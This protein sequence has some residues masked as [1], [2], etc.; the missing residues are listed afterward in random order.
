MR[1]QTAAFAFLVPLA[2]HFVASQGPA[3]AAMRSCLKNVVGQGTASS[4]LAAKKQAMSDWKAGAVA[5]GIENPAWR[6]AINKTFECE[7]DD[8]GQITCTASGDPCTITQV[9]PAST[10]AQ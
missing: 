3:S 4:E 5:A 8:N 10:E 6:I 9:P 2:F 7:P 1:H